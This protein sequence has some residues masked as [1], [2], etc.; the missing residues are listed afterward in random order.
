[1]SG[2]NTIVNTFLTEMDGIDNSGQSQLLVIGATNHI[3]KIDKAI[4]RSGRLGRHIEVNIPQNPDQ[5][6]AVLR[7]AWRN[8]TKSGWDRC[9]DET[10]SS[11]ADIFRVMSGDEYTYGWK[12]AVDCEGCSGTY[13]RSLAAIPIWRRW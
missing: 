6:F 8:E 9:G 5:K 12:Y 3:D 10:D 11:V 1:M 2:R 4:A 13:R 7:A